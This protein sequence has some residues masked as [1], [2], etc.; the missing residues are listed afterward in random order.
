MHAHIYM[1]PHGGPKFMCVYHIGKLFLSFEYYLVLG[2]SLIFLFFFFFII[3]III[4]ILFFLLVNL[5]LLSMGEGKKESFE[6]PYSNLKK[7]EQWV[8]NNPSSSSSSMEDSDVSSASCSSL[9]ITDD[10]SSSSSS[11]SSSAQDSINGSSLYDLSDL[12]TQLPIKRGLSKYYQGKS[13]SFTCL[14][15]VTSV[16][17]LVK[18][19]SPYRRRKMKGCKSYGGGLDTY[20]SYTMPKPI[21]CKKSFKGGSFSSSSLPSRNGSFSSSLRPPLVPSQKNLAMFK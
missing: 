11:Y 10:A 15:R 18:K 2:I 12:M 13:E 5:T 19:E 17:D 7:K 21:I 8:V 16:E 9:E 20:K 6:S 14:S 3:I 4:I 1:F